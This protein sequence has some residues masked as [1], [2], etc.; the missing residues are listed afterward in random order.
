MMGSVEEVDTN[1]D[2]VGWGEFLRVRVSL[3]FTKPLSRGRFLKLQGKFVWVDFQYERLPRYYFNCG[4][5]SH[6]K[7]GCLKKGVPRIQGGE[8]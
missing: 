1:F 3:D 7:E 6:G 8:A 5:I 2:V 4:I